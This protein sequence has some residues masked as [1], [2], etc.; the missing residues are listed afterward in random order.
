MNAELVLASDGA[1]KRSKVELTK[2]KVEMDSVEKA[3]F[4]E[5]VW[6]TVTRRSS[7]QKRLKTTVRNT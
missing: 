4:V 6:V 5:D 3:E 1:D 7:K 2:S